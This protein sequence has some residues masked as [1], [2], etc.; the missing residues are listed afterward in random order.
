[1]NLNED[2]YLDFVQNEA[3]KLGKLF[4][5][6]SGEGNDFEYLKKDWYVEDL[7]GWLIDE[8]IKDILIKDKE[9]NKAHVTFSSDYIFVKWYMKDDGELAIA[10]K[11]YS[12]C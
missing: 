2:A 1:M 3:K 5:L 8:N 9:C 6:D 11:R 4:V 10:F 12:E 7:S